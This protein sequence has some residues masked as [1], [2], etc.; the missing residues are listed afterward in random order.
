MRD[1]IIIIIIKL[2]IKI[3]V[4]SLRNKEIKIY[5]LDSIYLLNYSLEDLNKE[6]NF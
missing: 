6:F 3:I 2:D 5:F 1:I 4:G